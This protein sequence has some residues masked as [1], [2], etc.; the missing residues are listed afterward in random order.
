LVFS[1]LGISYFRS[2]PQE[3][4]LTVLLIHGNSLN[5]AFFQNQFN[6]PLLC[7]LPLIAIDLPGHGE[8]KNEE[9]Y[10]LATLKR[11]VLDFIELT[12]LNNFI[13]VGHSLGGHLAI[14]MIP[15]IREICK[16]IFIYG[17]P[18]LRQ[19]LN[20]TDAFHESK[21]LGY[22]LTSDLGEEEILE[23]A[24]SIYDARDENFFKIK[25]SITNTDGQFRNGF[26][27][28]LQEELLDE[29]ELLSGF[30]GYL[31]ILHGKHDSLVNLEYLKELKNEN[32]PQADLIILKKSGHSPH[33]EEVNTFNKTIYNFY[34]KIERS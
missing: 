15:E 6:D 12:S 1:N 13:I 24:E 17:T 30:R 18:P 9:T 21:A 10:S 32:L 4:K 16:G 26:G 14:Q 27:E 2:N 29:V 7:H 5:K 3:N 20:V 19:P 22:F 31:L 8:S 11:S 28:S 25:E 23:L 34:Q 33:L